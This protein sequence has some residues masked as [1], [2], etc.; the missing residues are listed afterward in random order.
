VVKKKK[1]HLLL[2]LLAKLQLLLAKL[3]SK[4]ATL[5]LKR[6]KKLLL[7]LLPLTKLLPLLAKLLLLL[8]KLQPPLTPLLKLL[9]PSNSGPGTKNRPLGRF[10][11]ACTSRLS[12]RSSKTQRPIEVLGKTPGCIWAEPCN[13]KGNG[14]FAW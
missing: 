9:L 7:L 12:T 3:Q 1:Q 13:G 2:K 14:Y 11:F 4:R 8:A 6:L 10:F 5:L